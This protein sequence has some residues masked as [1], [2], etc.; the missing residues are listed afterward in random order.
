M[1]WKRTILCRGW[2]S[3]QQPVIG[4]HVCQLIYSSWCS[5]TAALRLWFSGLCSHL[6]DRSFGRM[7][8]GW[9]FPTCPT[10]DN[11]HVKHHA[12][13][14]SKLAYIMIVLWL[15]AVTFI[16]LPVSIT[17]G[18]QRPLTI[19]MWTC[20]MIQLNA[21]HSSKTTC[22]PNVLP[23]RLNALSPKRLLAK[24]LVA[25]TTR[26]LLTT[27]T[28]RVDVLWM[29]MCCGTL[30]SWA[31]CCILFLCLN[32]ASRWPIEN[33]IGRVWYSHFHRLGA[34]HVE[35]KL[36]TIGSGRSSWDRDASCATVNTAYV[37]I[38]CICC[39]A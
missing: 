21:R 26:P 8:F 3:T 9:Q 4:V 30:H 17:G 35:A 11:L 33:L 27:A 20:Y 31:N 28:L 24:C 19:S 5:S 37:G 16:H 36:F 15:S 18:F 32:K 25:Q 2:R 10:T 1:C 7:T 38:R 29:W 13:N 23:I 34:Q 39:A 12:C 14:H 6:G 22:L